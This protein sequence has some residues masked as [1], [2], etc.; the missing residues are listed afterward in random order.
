MQYDSF[1]H[2]AGRWPQEGRHILAQYSQS[3]VIVYQAYKPS[4]AEY[5][6]AHQRF[7]GDFSFNRMSWIKPNF[8]WMMFRCGWAEKEGQERV[9]AITLRRDF[10]ERLLVSAVPSGFQGSDFDSKEAWQA[11]VARSDV[12][13]QWDPDHDPFGTPL[14]R[15]AIQ[16]GLRGDTLAEYATSALVGIEDVTE[17]V[18]RQRAYVAGDCAGLILPL[19]LVYVPGPDAARNIGLEIA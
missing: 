19:E 13:L 18:R 8:L 10:F 15:R 4:I 1:Q 9:L 12:R 7:G 17:F 14:A 2:Q 16:L 5:A 6:V 3:T 11:A